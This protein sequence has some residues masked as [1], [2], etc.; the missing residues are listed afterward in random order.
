MQ[1]VFE[2]NISLFYIMNSM[3]GEKFTLWIAGMPI[4]LP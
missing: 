2:S 4:H 3:D 1:Q